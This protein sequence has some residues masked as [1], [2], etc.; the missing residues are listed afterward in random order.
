[1]GT[2]IGRKR[3]ARLMTQADRA[4]VSRRRFVSTTVKGNGRQAPRGNRVNQYVTNG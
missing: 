4:G 2:R 1:M 3:V